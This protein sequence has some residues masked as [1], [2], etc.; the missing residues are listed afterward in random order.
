MQSKQRF[1]TIAIAY[2]LGIL[3]GTLAG[4]SIAMLALWH[5][6]GDPFHR[7]MAQFNKRWLNRATLQIAGRRDSP[8]AV[9]QHVGRSSGRQYVTPVMAAPIPGGFTIPLAYGDTSDWYRN[10]L[11]K[12]ECQLEWQGNTYRVNKPELVDAA[13]IESAFPIFW[14]GP[15]LSYGVNH[16]VKV[17]QA[18]QPAINKVEQKAKLA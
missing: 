2:L 15:M 18:E 9:L 5:I 14:R 10:L 4:F 13:A 16:F 17:S 12:G 8:Y 6:G 1:G 11:A 3:T 7:Q